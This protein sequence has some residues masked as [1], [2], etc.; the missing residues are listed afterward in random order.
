M[1][2]LLTV[3]GATGAQGGSV[4]ARVL[5]NSA[6]SKTWKVRGVT[7]DPTKPA[8]TAL[9]DKGVEVVSA[10]FGSKD[11]LVQAV[12]GSAAV[13]G[14]TNFW[15]LMDGEK[16]F[17]Q[18]KNLI[19]A[20][21][22]VGVERVIFSTLAN[23]SKGTN[24]RQTGVAHFDY[25][26]K[27]AEYALETGVPSTFFMPASYMSF[28]IKAFRPDEQGVYTWA[29]PMDPE[30]TKIP[31]IDA[32]ADSGLWVAAILLSLSAT[33][34]QRVAAAGDVLS[35]AQMAAQLADVGGVK[36]QATRISYDAF[37]STLPPVIAQEMASMF[38]LFENEGYYV[39]EPADA[40][41]K[42]RELVS[43]AGLPKPKTW[44]DYVAANFKKDA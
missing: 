19:D 17:Q 27:I 31:L 30:K 2:K 36:A 11:S 5:E 18:G 16:E 8:A 12:Q 15:E 34:N 7:R 10:D 28:M 9:K 6:L 23:V 26:A 43:K 33:L 32:S 25:K 1:T 42:G 38:D 13:F 14:V 39:G 29:S 24:G 41:E 22:Q 3:F 20:C 40:V 35:P 44:K 4:V 37:K 21:K